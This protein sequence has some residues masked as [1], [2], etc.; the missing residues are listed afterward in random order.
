MARQLITPAQRRLYEAQQRIVREVVEQLQR[1]W[2]EIPAHELARLWP[3]LGPLLVEIVAAG[4]RAAAS[5]AARAVKVVAADGAPVA[6][7]PAELV[8]AAFAGLA[9][10][11]RSLL[12]LLWLAVDTVVRG[13]VA[14]VAPSEAHAAG[15]HRL[16]RF[17]SGEVADTARVAMHAAMAADDRIVGYERVVVL[18]ACGR[19]VILAGRVYRWSEGFDRHPQCDCGMQPLTAEQWRDRPRRDAPRELFEAMTPA[20][21]K[22]AFTKGGLKAIE[23]G[24]DIA[25]VVNARRSMYKIGKFTATRDGTTVRGNAGRLLGEHRKQGGRYRR[26]TR[27][28][29]M[30]AEAVNR[31]SSREELVTWLRNAGYMR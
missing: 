10:D 21:R 17:A 31:A 4:Q 27:P 26:S 30:P 12:S 6:Q 22:K 5:Y 9:V 28:R 25:Q 20:Q 11:G 29:L 3:M 2:N 24:A 14:G 23:A 16:L 7:K 18:P 8:P 15:L 1:L 19:C 13:L